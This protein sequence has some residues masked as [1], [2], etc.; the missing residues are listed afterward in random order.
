[1]N[2]V[3]VITP[4]EA[5]K[6]MHGVVTKLDHAR[7]KLQKDKAARQ[8][9]Y[10]NWTKFLTDAI[11]RWQ[12]H[13]ENFAKED[14]ELWKAIETATSNFLTART[15]L[16][17]TKEALAEFD[18]VVEEGVQSIS[19]DDLMVDSP[20]GI[21]QGIQEMMSSLTRLQ[22]VQE[23]ADASAAKKPWKS[24]KRAITKM[25]LPVRR[26]LQGIAAFWWGQQIDQREICYSPLMIQGNP[27]AVASWTRSIRM[28]LIL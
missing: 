3:K 12:Q 25:G 11:Q 6:L 10:R 26:Y 17:E 28:K 15:H 16:E 14:V 18:N 13:S 20:P 8:N 21:S 5:S 27:Y 1:M 23:E 24:Q 7:A 9:M 2:K 4:K 22:E 19:D